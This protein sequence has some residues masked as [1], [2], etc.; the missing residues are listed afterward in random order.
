[1]TRIRSYTHARW[2]VRFAHVTHYSVACSCDTHDHDHTLHVSAWQRVSV[3]EGE[4]TL[5]FTF[6]RSL[7]SRQSIPDCIVF[8]V[9]NRRGLSVSGSDVS[10]PRCDTSIDGIRHRRNSPRRC[11]TNK[12][13]VNMW[14]VN[15]ATL[16]SRVFRYCCECKDIFGVSRWLEILI[17]LKYFLIVIDVSELDKLPISGHRFLWII[18]VK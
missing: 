3:S 12:L 14:I 16:I 4:T 1:M 17:H 2:A 8:T 10:D 15:K 9:S 5:I 7:R 11:E 13:F 6:I 18:I